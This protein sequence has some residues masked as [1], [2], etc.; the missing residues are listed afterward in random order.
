MKAMKQLLGYTMLLFTSLTVQAVDAEERIVSIDGSITEIIYA[1]EAQDKLV[2]V[3]STSRFPEAATQLPDVGYM[4]RLSTEGI[5]SLN[6]TLVIATQ[7]AGPESV[8]EELVD[9]GIHVQRIHNRYTLNGV[10]DK[11][12]RVAA[13]VGKPEEGKLIQQRIR[14]QTEK[15]LARIPAKAAPRTLF[16]LG[17]GDRGLMAAGQGTQAAAMLDLVRAENVVSYSGYK[18][19]SPEG[20]IALSPAVVIAAHTTSSEKKSKSKLEQTLTM[21]PAQ[22]NNRVHEVDVSLVLGFG[23]R[24]AEAM[25]TLVD[26][27]YP[28]QVVDAH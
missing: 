2:G 21:T 19:V 4:R 8:F 26:V 20:A 7:N 5:L 13:V 6:P 28:S 10:I 14:K 9:A 11:I 1:L 22:Q 25:E 27:L 17:A 12:N 3:D 18:P 15:V 24:I 16:I 23:P